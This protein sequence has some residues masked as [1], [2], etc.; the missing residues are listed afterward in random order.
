HVV[1]NEELAEPVPP[2]EHRRV[3]HPAFLEVHVAEVGPVGDAQA[4]GLAPHAEELADVR[5][6]H[7]LE[8]ALDRHQSSSSMR[9]S[10][11]RGQWMTTFSGPGNHV[12]P[13]RGAT[14]GG[15][16]SAGAVTAVVAAA[17]RA[18]V[19]VRSARSG[20]PPGPAPRVGAASA[21]AVT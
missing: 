19:P 17:A 2:V 4:A 8:R 15:A 16:G 3:D 5:Q 21:V 20:G 18:A 14:G 9:K 13:F 11:M 7:V 1:A 10:P 12:P 6:A